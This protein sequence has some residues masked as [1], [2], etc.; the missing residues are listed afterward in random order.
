M[1]W[2]A[3]SKILLRYFRFLFHLEFPY[4]FNTKCIF[5]PISILFQ[6]LENRF[7]NPI[8][9]IPRGNPEL[10]TVSHFMKALCNNFWLM[11]ESRLSSGSFMYR[12]YSLI[13]RT[14]F[15]LDYGLYFA[16][17]L[18][19]QHTQRDKVFYQQ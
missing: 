8:L 19:A 2:F 18:Y 4:F 13:S 6:G 11:T 14:F 15:Y 16:C 9:P 12:I 7:L 10:T 3:F 1:N 5:W 17:G